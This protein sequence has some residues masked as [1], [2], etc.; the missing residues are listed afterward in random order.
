MSL[1]VNLPWPDKKLSP[2]ARSSWQVRARVSKEARR[3]AFYLALQAMPD[4]GSH[5]PDISANPCVALRFYPA[6]ARRRDVDN[7][8]ASCKAYLDGIA[9][10]LKTDDS[11]FILSAQ[12]MEPSKPA[13]VEVV[14]S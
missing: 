12:M 9:D 5:M 6:D 8:I 1:I 10:S 2:N 4:D 7:A 14:I 11:K 13:R 3:T